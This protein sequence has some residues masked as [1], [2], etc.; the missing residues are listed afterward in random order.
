MKSQDP[1]VQA[2]KLFP[3]TGKLIYF[4]SASYGPYTS[5]ARHATEAY[6]DLRVRSDRD[7]TAEAFALADKLRG[8]YARLVGARKR[9]IGL[10]LNTSFGLNVAAFGLPL[11]RGD[12]VLI[13]AVE[14][15]AVVYTWK[16]A[17]E[18][19]KLSVKLAPVEDRCFSLEKLKRA[20]TRRTRVVCLSWVQFFNGYKID[21][22]QLGAFCREHDIYLVVDG[23]QGMG[24]E[25]INLK[26]LP[27]DIF[28]SGCQKWML[29]PQ[30][31]GFF[32]LSD[33]VRDRLQLPFASWLSV[34]WGMNFTDLFQFEQR[35][36]DSARRFEL[37]YYVVTNFFGM[38]AAADLFV[39]LG[40]RNIQ[41]HNYALIDRL[42]DYVRANPFYRITSNLE[43]PH[44]SSILTF[45]CPGYQNL[46][47]RILSRRII[48]AQRE[49]S[50]R[51]SVHLFNNEEDIDRLVEVLENFSRR[52]A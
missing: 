4:N 32:Y 29:S 1:F 50:I 36:Y 10:G 25:P 8:T 47:R 37:G 45:T 12:E 6:L 18:S 39:K 22:S 28:T 40:I 35:W 42:A 2:R 26:H 17:A 20:V 31:C 27:V 11:E 33:R 14:F 41:R 24:V 15:P 51:V 34:D 7:E 52:P 49:G 43:A 9:E 30:G 5:T 16:A 13:P 3:H 44:R 19:R 46:H 21:L 48:L 23:I 38:E